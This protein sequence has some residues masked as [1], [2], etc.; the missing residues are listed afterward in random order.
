ME[1]CFIKYSIEQ[2][3]LII[4]NYIINI[5]WPNYSRFTVHVLAP[6]TYWLKYEICT[7]FVK[8]FHMFV[9]K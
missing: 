3:T 8:T 2:D 9:I 5:Y 4:M 6:I 1:K 7:Y